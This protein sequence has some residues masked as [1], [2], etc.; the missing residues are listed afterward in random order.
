MASQADKPKN[1][2]GQYKRAIR[3]WQMARCA[4]VDRQLAEQK[5]QNK[6]EL[7]RKLDAIL[8][9]PDEEFGMDDLL[10]GAETAMQ[11]AML[12]LNP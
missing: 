4:E 2:A 9:A 12:D 1:H 11:I 10:E 3:G 6:I 5:R 8:A 7:K